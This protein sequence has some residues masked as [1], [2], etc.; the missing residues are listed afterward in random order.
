MLAHLCA[1]DFNAL[2]G[3]VCLFET[4]A[5]APLAMEIKSVRLKP[6]A[7]SPF[8]EPGRRTPFVVDLLGD[9]QTR[10][11]D[12][13]GILSVAGPGG[14]DVL[15]LDDVWISRVGAMG[16]GSEHAYFQLVFN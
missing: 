15:R 7:A 12:A 5:F 16:R 3:Q 10:V 13:V 14:H 9:P 4:P 1:E 6:L 8:G 11:V 2:L